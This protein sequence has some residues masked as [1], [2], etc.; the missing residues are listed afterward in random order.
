MSKNYG[1]LIQPETKK[2]IAT[3]CWH[4]GAFYT[5]FEEPFTLRSG[6]KSPYYIST[7]NIL[8]NP[9]A[10]NIAMTLATAAMEGVEYDAVA[11]GELRG[12]LFGKDYATATKKPFVVVRKKPKGYGKGTNKTDLINCMREEDIPG[13]TFLLCEDLITN[14]GSKLDFIEAIRGADGE[15]KNC[16]VFVD[17]LFGGQKALSE[18]GV[19]LYSMT[20]LDTIAEVGK[21]KEFLTSDQYKSIKEYMEEPGEWDSKWKSKNK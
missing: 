8:G 4:T 11:G 1:K 7:E 6:L 20:D 17:R 16:L 10:T 3:A 15:V 5:N 13:K 14:G 2:I 18:V 9:I 19:E 12:A 21:D